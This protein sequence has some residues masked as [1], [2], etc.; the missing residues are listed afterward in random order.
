[1]IRRAYSKKL[2]VTRP[3]DDPVAFQAL[4]EAYQRAL[5]GPGSEIALILRTKAV[6]PQPRD[7]AEYDLGDDIIE[8]LRP[9]SSLSQQQTEERD[10]LL[11]ILD[12]L[13][14]QPLRSPNP[15][16]WSFLM[17]TPSLL[18]DEFRILVGTQVIERFVSHESEQKERRKNSTPVS[19]I[20]ITRLDDVFLWSARPLEFQHTTSWPG[21]CE[22]L[23]RVDPAMRQAKSLPMGGEVVSNH[24]K[25]RERDP[26]FQ[27]VPQSS[28][29]GGVAG[30]TV[31]AISLLMAFVIL[32]SRCSG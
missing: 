3:D 6:Q 19:N 22:I 7:V 28:G 23:N 13:L 15:D 2:K 25:R 17:E 12:E 30:I 4:Y 32:S 10:I 5:S 14:G 9:R 1:M 16:N 20:V 27:R 31:Y 18:E 8:E 11:E 26:A 24:E 29:E 21:F